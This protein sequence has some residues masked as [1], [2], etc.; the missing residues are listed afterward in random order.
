[1]DVAPAEFIRAGDLHPEPLVFQQI[2]EQLKCR[3][4]ESFRRIHPRHVIDDYGS[5]QCTDTLFLLEQVLRIN[6][7][8]DGPAELSCALPGMVEDVELD[9]AS[10]P[11]EQVETDA[12]D[13]G[14]S[15]P[16]QLIL[17]C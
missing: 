16:L 6:V 5:R 2:E 4:L 8:I 12:A 7:Q 14:V 13:A 3:L 10:R 1:M 15:Q 9:I 17:R 11:V